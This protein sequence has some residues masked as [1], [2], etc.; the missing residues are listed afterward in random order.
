MRQARHGY[1]NGNDFRMLMTGRIRD[2]LSQLL[3]SKDPAAPALRPGLVDPGIAQDSKQPARQRQVGSQLIGAGQGT[4]DRNMHQV[5]GVVNGAC[6]GSGEAPQPRQQGHDLLSEFFNGWRHALSGSTLKIVSTLLIIAAPAAG[7]QIGLPNVRLPTLPQPQLPG[8]V[9]SVT[10]SVDQS[11]SG[12]LTEVR[13]LRIRDLVRRNRATVE[14]DRAGMP[15]VRGEVLAVSPTDAQLT[16]A[17]AGGFTVV[18]VRTLDD[19]DMRIVVLGAPPG[20]DTLRAL[21]RLQELVPSANLDFNHIYTGSGSVVVGGNQPGIESGTSVGTSAHARLGLIDSGIDIT[22]VVFEGIAIHQHGCGNSPHPDPHGTA[23]ASLLVGRSAQ[24]QGAS[25]GS[26]L[27]AADVFCGLPTGGAADAIA[28]AFGW[29]AHEKVPVINVSLVGPPNATIEALVRSVLAR[30]YLIVAAVGNDGPA[31][32]PLYPASYPG[33][34]GVTG[35]DARRHALFEAGRGPQVKFAAPGADMVAARTSQTFEVVRGTSFAAPI[36]AGLLAAMLQEPDKDAAGRAVD[37]LARTAVDLGA[38]GMDFTYGYG[39]VGVNVAPDPRLA[40][41]RAR[42][43]A[44]L[45]PV[46]APE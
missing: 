15:I 2:T 44:A 18:R 32:A 23:V 11:T 8:A 46:P 1:L 5:V 25:P 13:R 10:E 12:A 24:F 31:A 27:Y 29:L 20:M 30:G 35:V 26:E 3:G 39:L 34:V 28:E 37:N 16:T 40:G 43:G 4:L 45:A 14:V 19:L 7:A 21:A 36:V 22:H 17:L 6:E 42:A 41:R 9:Q 33:V 38:V